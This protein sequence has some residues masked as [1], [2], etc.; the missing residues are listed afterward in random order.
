LPASEFRKGPIVSG[1]D[2]RFYALTTGGVIGFDPSRI[3]RG[4]QPP[5]VLISGIRISN[6]PL[7]V[8]GSQG[9]QDII[10]L[11][12][13]ASDIT[14][15]FAALSLVAP[16]RNQFAYRLEGLDETWVYAGNRRER[17]YNNLPPGEYRFV[18]KAADH[19]G[20]WNANGASQRLLVHPPPWMTIQAYIGYAVGLALLGLL[21][22]S[23]LRA[24]SHRRR[25]LDRARQ[26]QD[27]AETQ[28][29]MTL[30]LTS[31]LEVTDI[32]ERL[33]DGLL[34]IVSSD[35]AVVSVDYKGLPRA[36]VN[37]G[38]QSCDLP[39][40]TEV[41]KTIRQLSGDASREP[42]TL[43]AMGSVG[44]SLTVALQARDEYLGVVTLLR[45]RGELF[46]ERDRLMA[47]SYARQAGIA[48]ENARLFREVRELAEIAESANQAKS[49]FLAKMSHEIRTPM[50]GVLGMAEL[51]LQS[52]LKGDQR[53]YAQAVEDSG[54]VLLNIINDILDLSKIEA[55]KLQLEA[56]DVHLGQLL[57]E[58]IKLF[59]GNA[60]K[61]GLEF[62]YVIAPDV[63]RQ[64]VGDP[65][66]IRQ[67]LMNLLSNALKFT[68]K[69]RVR[70]DVTL[71]DQNS[72][73][74]VVKDTGIGMDT[75][76][77]QQL[78]QPFSQAE[79]STSR[80]Y[81]GTGLGLAI[82]KQLVE[83]MNGN[84]DAL[85]KVG[86]GSLFWVELPLESRS[87]ESPARLPGSDWLHTGRTLLLLPACVARESL[88]AH[89][90]WHGVEATSWQGQS[91]QSL[92]GPPVLV[93]A[94][95]SLWSEVVA[96]R[97]REESRSEPVIIWVPIDS[98][99]ER[100]EI[101]PGLRDGGTL[102]PPV[103]ESELV[104]RILESGHE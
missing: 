30:S 19:A 42:T 36:Q 22:F 14:F 16:D 17:S 99:D 39:S 15:E 102:K 7:S 104:L 9:S 23:S 27:W 65:V 76:A 28:R 21:I 68:D 3:E 29:D 89:L 50:N 87:S 6:Q 98:S 11:D 101:G 2:D 18:V 95:P 81:G 79:E 40:F 48:L 83:H 38:F 44:R 77:Y 47:G 84:I 46:V 66:R 90:A 75:D 10:E 100:P 12:Y 34:E 45:D 8:S 51:L 73:R 80:R 70:L 32:L 62:G 72:I 4:G 97:L 1:P 91:E 78:F 96:H 103:F 59:S 82:C 26:R 93:F 33:L 31:T 37:R 85:T 41:G 20:V 58:V 5:P 57:E 71:G 43:S 13:D 69:G 49:D 52:G 88:M 24:R 61:S 94:C 54:K 63:P 25:E 55:G 86:H 67:V 64:V 74:F 35:R 60:A 56:L 53:Q 92:A